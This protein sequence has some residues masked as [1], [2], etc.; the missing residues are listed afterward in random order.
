LKIIELRKGI[1]LGGTRETRGGAV[2]S[3]G[4]DFGE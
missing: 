4:S 3:T 1:T 2:K